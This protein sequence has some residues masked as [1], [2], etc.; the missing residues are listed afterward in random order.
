MTAYNRSGLP[1][2]L[3][4]GE[5]CSDLERT[6]ALQHM[7]MRRRIGFRYTVAGTVYGSHVLP[8]SPA[9]KPAPATVKEQL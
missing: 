1:A 7:A 2:V 9:F 8:Y 5:R 4:G 6:S 3:L